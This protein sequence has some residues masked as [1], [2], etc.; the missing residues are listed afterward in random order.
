MYVMKVYVNLRKK[1]QQKPKLT[2]KPVLN[3]PYFLHKY[4]INIHYNLKIAHISINMHKNRIN[5]RENR[6]TEQKSYCFTF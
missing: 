6:T 2:I 5:I 4:T 1:T 3:F